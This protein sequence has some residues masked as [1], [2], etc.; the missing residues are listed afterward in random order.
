MPCPR[1]PTRGGTNGISEVNVPPLGSYHEPSTGHLSREPPEGWQLS[2]DLLAAS[3]H[4][5]FGRPTP[6]SAAISPAPPTASSVAS[7]APTASPMSA[8]SRSPAT[9]AAHHS[10]AVTAVTPVTSTTPI[11][12]ATPITSS[13]SA[14]ASPLALSLPT[15]AD[16]P[17]FPRRYIRRLW[18]ES[19]PLPVDAS[20]PLLVLYTSGSTGKPK[21]IVHTHGG[22]EVGLCAT[23][24]AVFTPQPTLDVLL[25]VAT[26]GWITGAMA[27]RTPLPRGDVTY[28]CMLITVQSRPSGAVHDVTLC[29]IPELNSGQSYMIAAALL[30]RLTSVLLEGSPVSPPDRF[31]SIIERRQVSVLKAGERSICKPLHQLFHIRLPST[32]IRSLRT[33]HLHLAFPDASQPPSPVSFEPKLLPFLMVLVVTSTVPHTVT[34]T[35]TPIVASTP[36]HRLDVPSNAH[37]EKWGARAPRKARFALPSPRHL[38]R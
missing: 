16:L 4:D 1:A 12:S 2:A 27:A 18:R 15:A 24:H 14:F 3:L 17:P 21:G 33:N 22:Y 26:P 37:V 30:C 35:V 13:A 8:D 9:P 6:R 25:V 20:R 36:W 7:P 5:A 32:A 11:A 31:A 29:E 38:L 23:T 19:A 28:A 34:S 10:S